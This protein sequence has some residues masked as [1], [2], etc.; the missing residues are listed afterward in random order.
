MQRSS[1][2]TDYGHDIK[3]LQQNLCQKADA[4][5]IHTLNSNVARL[6]RSLWEASA[7]IDGLRHRIE[8]LQEIVNNLVRVTNK[9]E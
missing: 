5:E 1:P 6:E 9:E 3:A 8:E 7:E 4:H 2:F